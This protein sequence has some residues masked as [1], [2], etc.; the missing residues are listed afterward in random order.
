MNPQS[1][2][3]RTLDHFKNTPLYP[4][5]PLLFIVSKILWLGDDMYTVGALVWRKQNNDQVHIQMKS[6]RTD[7]E[8][9]GL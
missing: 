6:L 5:E 9:Q 8:N 3:I 1:Y 2:N 4:S 7:W